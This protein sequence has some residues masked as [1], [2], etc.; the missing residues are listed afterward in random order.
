M[1]A[2]ALLLTL[3]ATADPLAPAR[4]GQVQCYDPVPAQK[5]CRA[6][7]SYE[8]GADGSISNLATTRLQD[9]PAI[10]M[11]ARSPVVIRDGKECS[12]GPLKPEDIEKIEVNG[13]PLDAATLTIARGQIVAGLPD[14][15]KSG[16]LLCSAYAPGADGTT[17]ATVDIG[18]VAHPELTATILWVN[19]AEGWKVVP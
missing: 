16:Q 4:Q 8:F 15:L 11:F 17:T 9:S 2:T 3:A 12:V 1:L 6:I 18:G 10:V 7:G 14:F 5:L 13:Q 19:P